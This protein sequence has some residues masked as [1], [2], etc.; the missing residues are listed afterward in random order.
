MLQNTEQQLE[1]QWAMQNIEEE[2]AEARALRRQK[3]KAR[4][5][6]EAITQPPLK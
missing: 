6:Q 3:E 5:A 2:K 4:K 1:R